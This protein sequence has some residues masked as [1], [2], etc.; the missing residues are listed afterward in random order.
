[1]PKVSI[2]IPTYNSAKTIEET[3]ASIQQQSFTNWELI[4]IDDGSQDNTVDVI[5]NIVEPRLQ[6]FV[7]ENGGVGI[8]RNRGIAQATG[9][10]ITFLDADDLWT[11]DKLTLQ[12]EAL[13]QN[14]QAKVA[15]SWTS[16][17]DEQ[18]KFLFSGPRFYYRGNIFKELLQKNFLLSASNILIH[19]DVL[20]LVS[21]F[22]PEFSYAAD[23]DFYLRLAQNFDFALVPQYQIFYRQS[24]NSMS[25][26]IED[27]KE[28]CLYALDQTFEVAAQELMYL[29]NRS[30]SN[31]YLYC[32][33]LY[34]KKIKFNDY[35]S[36]NDAWHN[37]QTAIILHP[38]NLLKID[39]QRIIIKLFF[40]QLNFQLSNNHLTQ[41]WC[42]LKKYYLSVP[43]LFKSIINKP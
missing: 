20:E 13:K 3:I 10:F 28:Q 34:R 1:M 39:T 29:K 15:Y 12:I 23:W 38:N 2:I 19:R 41:L 9:E 33:D 27:M 43:I 24:G 36:L 8:A 40:W 21:G 16:Y 22:T 37:L 42:K 7:Y 31:F 26:K 5:K 14:P 4:I 11:C 25:S 32:A 17:I 30:H 6:I 35:K 18:G